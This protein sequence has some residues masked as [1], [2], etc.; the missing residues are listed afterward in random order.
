MTEY[1][2]TQRAKLKARNKIRKIKEIQ[3]AKLYLYNGIL[4]P[5]KEIVTK[6]KKAEENAK[7][8]KNYNLVHKLNSFFVNGFPVPQT[9]CGI[10]YDLHNKTAVTNSRV[11]C[12][13]C[14]KLIK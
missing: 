12:T 5:W 9:I 11:T 6:Q 1:Q 4:T 2:K 14:K 8:R 3:D 13:V 7:R 10:S